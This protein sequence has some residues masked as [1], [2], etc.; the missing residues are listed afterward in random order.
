PGSGPAFMTG[1][2]A[3]DAAAS[4]LAELIE[5]GVTDVVISPGS[6]SQALALA[7]THLARLGSLRVHVRIDERV[8]G[9]TALGIGRETGVPA[10]VICTSGTAAANL[11]PAAMEAFH[12]GVPLL[13]LTADRPPELRGIGANQATTQ[14]GMFGA[15]VRLQVDA[16]VADAVNAAGTVFADLA[17]QAVAA[18]VG[19]G[20]SGLEGVAGA[21]HLNLPYREPLSSA[22]TPTAQ[23]PAE[24]GEAPRAA[25]SEPFVLS[26][27]PRTIVVAGADA[28]AEAE[29]IAHEGGWPLIAE[30]V[31]GARFGRQL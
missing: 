21:V 9:F 23:M 6:R 19:A 5:D 2:R 12:A 7:A 13:L 26:R 20:G 30:I 24:L 11:L 29:R 14:P 1:S 15:W 31:S 8:A 28:G 22:M 4:L 16:P 25:A 27:G 18:A 17:A 10:A 3:S